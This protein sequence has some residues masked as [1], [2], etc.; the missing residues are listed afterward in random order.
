MS[1]P[2]MASNPAQG[3]SDQGSPEHE[4]HD[5]EVL[6]SRSTAGQT[7]LAQNGSDQALPLQQKRGQIVG[8]LGGVVQNVST[9][10]DRL[11]EDG[12]TVVASAFSMAP[13]GKGSNSAVAVHR[14]TRPNPK[15]RQPHTDEANKH[16]IGEADEHHP[17]F[18]EDVHVRM[19][20]AVGKD[21]FGP[22]L[23]QNLKDC[24]I[25]VDGVRVV[26]GQRTTLVRY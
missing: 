9:I 14:L 22:T 17:G 25:N 15:N 18:G 8:V 10:T 7:V 6:A 21:R 26:E 3:E 24:G 5:K 1:M 19:V 12:E 4:K 11:P 20:G 13:G 16:S 23:K 2:T